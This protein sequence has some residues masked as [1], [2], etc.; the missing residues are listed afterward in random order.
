[1]PLL[2]GL[3]LSLFTGLAEFFALYMAKRLAVTA[4][5][6]TAFVSLLGVLGAAVMGLAAGV[7]AGMPS[8]SAF[9]TGLY[10]AVPSNAAAC[11]SAWLACD[12]ACGAYKIGITQVR[13]A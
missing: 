9:M 8:D 1:M 6:L 10:F 12:A 13:I 2:G 7:V 3:L 4:A 5:A 11:L